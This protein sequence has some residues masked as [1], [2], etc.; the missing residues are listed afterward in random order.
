MLR[1]KLCIIKLFVLFQ[2][3]ESSVN[4]RSCRSNYPKQSY[5]EIIRNRCFDQAAI[6]KRRIVVRR[7]SI[8]SG[9]SCGNQEIPEPIAC[10]SVLK[11]RPFNIRGRRKSVSWVVD[12]EQQNESRAC[13][14]HYTT[15]RALGC[16]VLIERNRI[17]DEA[18]IRGTNQPTLSTSVCAL[19]QSGAIVEKP[20]PTNRTCSSSLT[21]NQIGASQYTIKAKPPVDNLAAVVSGGVV[22]ISATKQTLST[23]ISPIQSDD[24]IVAAPGATSVVPSPSIPAHSSSLTPNKMSASQHRVVMT[25]WP[26]ENVAPVVPENV[27]S[28]KAA[29]K[30]RIPDL[31]RY[32]EIY[33]NLFEDPIEFS[34]QPQPTHS[35]F[36]VAHLVME[37]VGFNFCIDEMTA[38]KAT[39]TSTNIVF[40]IDSIQMARSDFGTLGYEASP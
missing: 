16:Y 2:F 11:S 34:I 13:D 17:F 39:V 31:I 1:E 37:H 36:R 7:K 28:S 5:V 33:P 9:R 6:K 40:D 29:P 35:R 22:S 32:D 15:G 12:G 14:T 30:R 10:H 21:P 24:I 27:V 18:A 25:K 8:A 19:K 26:A 38:N 3:Q 23:P 20:A 4:T